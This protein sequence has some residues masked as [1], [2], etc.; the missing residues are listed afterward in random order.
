MK[1]EGRR[2]RMNGWEKRK[3]RKG[4]KDKSKRNG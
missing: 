2:G 4:R 3:R 1:G